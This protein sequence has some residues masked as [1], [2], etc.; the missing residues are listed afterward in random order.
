MIIALVGNKLDL[1][2]R[3]QVSYEMARQYA[4]EESLIFF[5]VSAKTGQNVIEL[6]TEIAKKL[7]SATDIADV[8]TTAEF[9]HEVL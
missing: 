4:K 5:E 2:G 9:K 3:R 7:I 8:V 6:F 1:D